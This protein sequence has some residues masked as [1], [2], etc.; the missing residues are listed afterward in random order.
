[1]KPYIVEGDYGS[2]LKDIQRT[3]IILQSCAHLYCCMK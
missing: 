3:Y 1:M 2:C